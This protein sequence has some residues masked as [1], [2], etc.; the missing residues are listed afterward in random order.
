MDGLSSDVLR[1]LNKEKEGLIFML[2]GGFAQ[3]KGKVIDKNK[4]HV[5]ECAHP[6]PM[7]GSEWNSCTHFKEA[8]EI[9]EQ[10]GKDK[11][12]WKISA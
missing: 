2:W 9:L 10:E 6:S 3:K 8:N 4:H 5:L 7:G 12:D 11:I 1:I